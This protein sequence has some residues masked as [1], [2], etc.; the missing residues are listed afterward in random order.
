MHVTCD[1]P[2]FTIV[3]CLFVCLFGTRCIVVDLL[4]MTMQ[5]T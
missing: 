1:L 4:A 2:G 5:M 3:L